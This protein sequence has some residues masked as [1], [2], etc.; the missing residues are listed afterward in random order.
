MSNSEVAVIL[1]SAREHIRSDL[2]NRGVP[3][4]GELALALKDIAAALEIIEDAAEA[5][6]AA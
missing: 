3:L 1:R 6:A 2:A 5:D 4:R